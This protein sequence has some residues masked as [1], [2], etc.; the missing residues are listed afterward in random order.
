MLEKVIFIAALVF[1]VASLL[2]GAF[3]SWQSGKISALEKKIALVNT[4]A[5]ECR[6]QIERQN[7]L[8]EG[9]KLDMANSKAEAEML[10]MRVKGGAEAGRI[11]VVERLVKD[12]TC[13]ERLQVMQEPI[14][15][16]YKHD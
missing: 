15:G 3:I 4:E 6:E 2:A 10:R 1:A 5:A 7:A 11:R 9:Y 12:N 8:I 14:D 16:F 13:E